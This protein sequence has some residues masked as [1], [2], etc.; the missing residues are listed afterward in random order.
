[1]RVFIEVSGSDNACAAAVAVCAIWDKD[2]LLLPLIYHWRYICEALEAH[3]DNQG[4][5]SRPDELRD[6][7]IGVDTLRAAL[8][9]ELAR[10]EQLNPTTTTATEAP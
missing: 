3:L 8:V 1:M 4:E 9:R 6:A 7:L 2:A 10:A 5:W